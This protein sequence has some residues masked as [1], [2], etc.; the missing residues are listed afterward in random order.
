MTLPQAR[1]QAIL[2]DL[3]GTLVDSFQWLLNLHNRVRVQMGEAPWTAQEFEYYSHSSS[4]V[5]YPR[6]YGDRAPAA[7]AALNA[8]LD[9]QDYD[10]MVAAPGANDLL[11]A[12]CTCQIPLGLVSNK[13]HAGLVNDVVHYGWQDMFQSVVG[14]GRAARDKPCPDPAHLALT[15]MQITAQDP[16]N[17]WYIGDTATD[18]EMAAAAGFFMVVVGHR[19]PAP[20]DGVQYDTLE[21][22]HAAISSLPWWA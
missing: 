6:L 5:I 19:V 8:E 10:G 3:D 1:P 7:F 11:H 12:L 9:K 18:V 13:T 14:A 2:F 20:K 17:I 4:R 22:L 21:T 15:E 16:R